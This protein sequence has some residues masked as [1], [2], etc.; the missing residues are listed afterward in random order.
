MKKKIVA[1]LL[2][3]A[4]L[5]T[6]VTGCNGSAKKSQDETSVVDTSETGITADEMLATLDYDVSDYIKLGDYTNLKVEINDADFDVTDDQIEEELEYYLLDYPSY[7]TLDKKKVEDGDKVN[8]DYKGIL[9]GEEFDGG[10]AEGYVLTIGSGEFIEGFE[11]QLIGSKVGDTKTLHLKFPENYTGDE[12]MDGKDVDFEV[13]IN[14]IVEE[15]KI[16]K[17]NITD[18]YVEKNMKDTL[19]VSTVKELK[20]Y[21]K[22]D[23]AEQAEEGKKSEIENQ[24][25]EKLIEVSEVNIP[26]EM[27]DS[28]IND[29]KTS[30]EEEAAESE[31]ELDEYLS[32]SYGYESWEAAKK[33]ISESIPSQLTEYMVLDALIKEFDIQVTD[34]ELEENFGFYATMNGYDD[35]DKFCEEVGGKPSIAL[36]YAE[37]KART[38]LAEKAGY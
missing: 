35:F 22:K 31:M 17:D 26:D 23:L 9:D 21:I 32:E 18:E 12:S 16:S 5:G 20:K 8:I 19:G 15:E 38:M 3:G 33:E 27:I 1:L 11:D 28:Q 24:L 4:L 37:Q 30:L 34:E 10:T 13:K 6:F 29:Y 25:L 14:S 2:C 7:K 36:N